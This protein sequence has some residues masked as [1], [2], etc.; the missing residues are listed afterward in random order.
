MEYV[1]EGCNT[2]V[3]KSTPVKFAMNIEHILTNRFFVSF[4]NCYFLAGKLC[5]KRGA[6]K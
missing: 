4:W 3:K 2:P 5:H 1:K 6:K